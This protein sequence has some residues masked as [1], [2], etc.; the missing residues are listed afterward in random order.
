MQRRGR[1]TA[2]AGALVLAGGVLL[3]GA[4]AAQTPA[5]SSDQI[6]PPPPPGATFTIALPAG[7]GC[8]VPATH[9]VQAVP[10]TRIA[11]TRDEFATKLAAA[12]G[13]PVADVQ[14]A[15]AETAPP[16]IAQGEVRR[17]FF[18]FG[19][20]TSLAPA[21]RQL[22]VT[23]AELQAALV[24]GGKTLC[25]NPPPPPAAGEPA[26]PPT[27]LFA[28]VAEVL[29]RGITAAGVQA[30]LEANRPSGPPDVTRIA[31]EAGPV[32]D[33]L[34]ALASALGVTVEALDAALR[35]LAPGL[36]VPPPTDR[37]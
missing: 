30:A 21:A 28:A 6:P 34:Q 12:L 19:D 17:V 16:L 26:G 23:P 27:A 31:I 9:A 32:S 8:V 20:E 35:S 4:A 36:P 24:E 10:A 7:G 25:E 1:L 15:L 22:G 33:H 29:G 11:Q 3:T 37:P 5:N 13:K 2:A 18:V 14:R